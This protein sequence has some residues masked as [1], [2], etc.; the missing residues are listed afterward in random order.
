[1]PEG[2]KVDTAGKELSFIASGKQPCC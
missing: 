2:L 1:M